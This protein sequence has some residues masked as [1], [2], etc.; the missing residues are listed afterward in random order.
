MNTTPEEFRP[1][2]SAE[3]KEVAGKIVDMILENLT[4]VPTSIKAISDMFAGGTFEEFIADLVEVGLL[5]EE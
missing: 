1:Q 2:L 5:L 4:A 3:H